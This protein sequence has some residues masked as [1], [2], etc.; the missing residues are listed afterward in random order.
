[1]SLKRCAGISAAL[2]IAAL[3]FGAALATEPDKFTDWKRTGSP[4]VFWRYCEVISGGFL[5]FYKK[6]DCTNQVPH[7]ADDYGGQA[8]SV[9]CRDVDCG[10]VSVK[11]VFLDGSLVVEGSD[12]QSHTIP[13]GSMANFLFYPYRKF[14]STRLVEINAF[15]LRPY[16]IFPW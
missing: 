3:S 16:K 4:G 2:A 15:G 8:I 10:S 14:K 7:Y 9:W 11:I 1:M 13:R 5:S 6:L 12:L